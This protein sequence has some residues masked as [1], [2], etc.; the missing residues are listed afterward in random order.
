VRRTF[1]CEALMANCLRNE[2]C[3]FYD[4]YMASSPERAAALR[5]R[6]C[7]GTPLAC[8]RYAVAKARGTTAVPLTLF[9]DQHAEARRLLATGPE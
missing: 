8:A 5:A 1:V 2:N 9:P 6:Y 4:H 7:E 3:P